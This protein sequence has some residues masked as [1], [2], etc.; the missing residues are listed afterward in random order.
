MLESHVRSSGAPWAELETSLR[1]Q[2]A[3]SRLSCPLEQLRHTIRV[4]NSGLCQNCR[5]PTETI[6][7]RSSWRFP[8]G[9]HITWPANQGSPRVLYFV[10]LTG[11]IPSMS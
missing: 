6:V 8:C 9:Y 7:V 4:E 3:R 11:Y 10:F 5:T 1:A 2:M